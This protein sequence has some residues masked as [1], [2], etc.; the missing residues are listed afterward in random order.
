M[1]SPL[2]EVSMSKI[3]IVTF[4]FC[5]QFFA[6][7]AEADT[8]IKY[9]I[10]I[11]SSITEQAQFLLASSNQRE[12][13]FSNIL[14]SEFSIR[15]KNGTLIGDGRQGLTID[16]WNIDVMITALKKGVDIR[17]KD[18]L[19]A[20][21]L[22]GTAIH[23]GLDNNQETLN[24]EFLKRF[25]SDLIKAVQLQ[26][27]D[28]TG[29]RYLAQL[30]VALGRESSLPY[31]LLDTNVNL[32]VGL[33]AVQYGLL[34]QRLAAEFWL[35]GKKHAPQTQ[36]PAAF[37]FLEFDI[38]A[39]QPCTMTDTE[40]L[41]MDAFAAGSGT[42]ASGF[43]EHL[44]ESKFV[45]DVGAEKFNKIAGAANIVLNYVKLAWSVAAFKATLKA[46]KNPLTRT[47]TK[48]AGEQTQVAAQFTMDG[49]SAQVVNCLRPALNMV[50]LDF[51]LPQ[52]GPLAGSLVEWQ[53]AT[54]MG[55]E[56]D[57]VQTVGVDPLH[58]ITDD[59]GRNAI[60]IEGKSQKTDL[61]QK[62][63]LQID[64]EV[65]IVA[66][67]NLKNK[68]PKQDA[69]DLFSGVSGLVALWSLP[70]ELLNRAPLLFS[71][72][73]KLIVHDWK[74]LEG[75]HFH[76]EG[77]YR[78][79]D[80]TEGADVQVTNIT[81]KLAF[82]FEIKIDAQ[83]NVAQT[84][85]L[86]IKDG[87]TEYKEHLEPEFPAGEGC[88][89]TQS[90]VG[91]YEAFVL[92]DKPYI[93][94]IYQPGITLPPGVTLPPDVQLPAEGMIVNISV[95]GLEHLRGWKFKVDNKSCEWEDREEGDGSQLIG[96]Q[97]QFDSTQLNQVGKSITI[98][99]TTDGEG[100]IFVVTYVE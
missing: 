6:I 79:P 25:Q 1:L 81:D 97:L 55:S 88:T 89:G 84:Q 29:L 86:S 64:R 92:Q 60:T 57:V 8:T 73:T 77:T 7:S 49:S 28:T 38:K 16:E 71:A 13:L 94:A 51:S 36:K 32:N 95:S 4:V 11:D 42:M 90:P 63:L 37:K 18:Y 19:L 14:N 15:Q 9:P 17:L 93:Q 45:S 3:A 100:W 83:T 85:I 5:L 2:A 39:S 35:L 98:D 65:E 23:S 58:Q 61:S 34:T 80:F 21:Q 30:I 87:K 47:K 74:A 33:N 27:N 24:P 53:I 76:V 40:G 31:D 44:V 26:D 43:L 20:W 41:I 91:E 10:E 67:V 46:E 99:D 22:A 72:K 96:G 82:D 70:A 62:K 12:I 48:V 50:G 56:N 54:R 75:D 52:G 69:I 68:N 59:N 66:S 78:R